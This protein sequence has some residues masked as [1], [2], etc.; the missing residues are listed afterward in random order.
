MPCGAPCIRLPCNLRCSKTLSCGH[1]CPSICGEIC[2]EGYCHKCSDKSDAR[3]DILEMKTYGEINP[4]ETPIVAL[5]CGHFFTTET[6]DGLVGMG[7]VYMMDRY[8]EFTGLKDVS[9]R[10]AHSVPRCPD[11]QRPVRQH[12]TRRYNRVVNRAVID[13]MSK[14][15]LVTGQDRLHSLEGEIAKLEQILETTIE[16]IVGF[17]RSGIPVVKELTER[18]GKYRTI[19]RKV[20]SFREEMAD[21]HQPALKLHNAIIHATR[22]RPIDQLMTGLAVTNVVPA[23]PRDR[24]ITLGGQIAEMKLDHII[25]QDMLKY[26]QALGLNLTTSTSYPG[27]KPDKLAILFFQTGK[28]I[29]SSCNAESLPK[30]SVEA[31]LY[32]ARVARQYESYCRS[33]SENI[34]QA[35]RQVRIAKELL[36]EARIRCTQGFRNADKLL[37][38]VEES[39]KL[40]QREWYEEV[41]EEELN[42]IKAAMVTGSNGIATHSGHWYNCANGHAVSHISTPILNCS[43]P[44]SSS[45]YFLFS[46]YRIVCNWRMRYAYGA[47]LLPGMWSPYWRSGPPASSGGYA[48]DKYGRLG[49]RLQVLYDL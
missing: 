30:L 29:V 45:L 16:S 4:D 2:P 42:T 12:S 26:T 32:F 40:L 34:S 25:L 28:S 22:S 41:T 8:G 38:A 9:V 49:I 46:N 33:I 21:T 27:G 14:R 47:S 31:T 13:E 15:F 24:A 10:L 44:I 37:K 6:L 23:V 17:V 5:G 39:I 19:R 3:V 20:E 1:Q 18:Y 48:R 43:M 35:S 11:C 7:E 36:D